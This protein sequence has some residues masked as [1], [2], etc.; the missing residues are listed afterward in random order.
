LFKHKLVTSSA[1]LAVVA[2]AITIAPATA[3]GGT[4]QIS[5]AGVTS[6]RSAAQGGSEL[7]WPEIRSGGAGAVSGGTQAPVEAVAPN[8]SHSTERGSG[9][10][11]VGNNVND[12]TTGN[13]TVLGSF[14]GL[15]HRNQRRANGGNQ[16]SV[17]PPDQGL[18]VGNGYVV[19]AVNTVMRVYDPAGTPLA[20]VMD[21]NTFFGYHAQF[22]RTTGEIGP[23]VTDP[24]CYFDTSTQ[25]WFLDV[26]TLDVYPFD[27]PANHITGGDLTGTNHLDLAVSQTASPLGSWTI[28]RV[29]V[30]DDGTQGTPNHGCTGIPPFRSQ[31]TNP[32]A[33]IGDYPHIGA[34]A[35]GIYLTTNEYSLFGNDFHGAQLYAFSKQALARNDANVAV[36]QI[37]THGMDNGNSGF[38]LWPAVAAGGYQTANNGTESF[39]SS[40]AADEAHG[41]GVAVGPRTSTQLL[42]WA[43]ANTASLNSDSPELDLNHSVLRVGRYS[44]PPPSTQKVGDTPLRDCLNNTDCAT[45][46]ILGFPDP[47]APNPEYALDS[48][49]TRMQQVVYANGK[50]WGAL[51]TALRVNGKVQAAIEWFVVSPLNDEGHAKLDHQGYLGVKGGNVIYP[52]IGATADGQGVMAFTL[53]GPENF[54]SAAFVTVNVHGTGPVQV[55]AAGLGPADG[56]SGYQIFNDPNPNRPRWGDYGAAVVDGN[57]LW[58]ASEY[59]GQTCN[60]N[61]YVAT[62]GS[63]GGTRSALGNWYTRITHVQVGSE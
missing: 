8:R 34:D 43:L 54:P 25:R 15:N 53:V 24:A 6:F 45:N 33:C 59:I 21:L 39:L 35:N 49:D 63:C 13:A 27:D 52:A 42:V 10:S 38:T 9:Q 60:L 20:G 12:G 17:E 46:F 62:G 48:N 31:P 29:P 40:N 57:T 3:A 37:D 47:H 2:S 61:T 1:V 26:L 41:N 36:T 51:D 23:F 30:Q 50:I 19:E 22:N 5:A 11:T 28:Y 18:C 58:I 44:F 16:F 4:R 55:A 32:N 7:A 56:F 14:N